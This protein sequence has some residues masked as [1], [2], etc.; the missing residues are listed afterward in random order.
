M[1]GDLSETSLAEPSS[2]LPD[3]VIRGPR[4][5]LWRMALRIAAVLAVALAAHAL[6]NL[7][8]TLTET[9]PAA[10]RGWV[11][12]VIIAMALL[13]YMILIAIPFVPGVEIGFSLLML[14]GAAIAPA[15]YLATLLGLALAFFV[16]RHVSASSI[17]RFLSDL[18][19][20]RAA[21]HVLRIAPLTAEERLAA[22]EARLPRWLRLPLSRARYLTLGVLLNLPG[23][24]LLGGGGGLM[25]MAGLSRVFDPRLTM[26][27]I[28]LAVLPVPLVIWWVGPG[29]LS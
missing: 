21:A 9:L 2:R 14:Q 3:P 12:A 16:G 8:M 6:I 1:R 5:A 17:A 13:V 10:R 22:M 11:L 4:A 26:L 25:L 27:T 29:L 15:V 28:S 20:A 23:N 24:A 19:L 18:G 7:S